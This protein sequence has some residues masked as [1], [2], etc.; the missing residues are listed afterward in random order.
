[1]LGRISARVLSGRRHSSDTLS[2]EVE[3][4]GE[5]PFDGEIVQFNDVTATIVTKAK[6]GR[7]RRNT[8]KEQRAL[9]SL[10]GSLMELE[11]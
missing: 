2:F 10:A 11:D 3:L 5:F 8:K 4:Y 1:M 7:K 6:P 9:H